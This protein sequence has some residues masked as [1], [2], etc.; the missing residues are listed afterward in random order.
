METKQVASSTWIIWLT[1]WKYENNDFASGVLKIRVSARS[2]SF[3]WNLKL[4]RKDAETLLIFLQD[5][6]NVGFVQALYL[7]SWAAGG[8]CLLCRTD[9]EAREEIL[10]HSCLSVKWHNSREGRWT[11]LSIPRNAGEAPGWAIH[12]K[13]GQDSAAP[14]GNEREQWEP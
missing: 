5:L 1:I 10:A 7:S 3:K 4:K 9:A 13:G 12:E 8:M 2:N 11:E 6:S 14:C